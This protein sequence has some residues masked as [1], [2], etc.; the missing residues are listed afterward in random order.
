M[1]KN[2]IKDSLKVLGNYA[3]ALLIYVILLYTFI[4]I[5]GDNFTKWLPLYSFIIFLLMSLMLYTDLWRLAAKEKRP[6]YNLNPYPLKGLILGLIG[7][8]PLIIIKIIEHFITFED[9]VLNRLKVS[10]V[11]GVLLG[12]LYF[13]I[14]LLGKTAAAYIIALLIV[15][16]LS[17]LGYMLGYYGIQLGKILGLKKE[18]VYERKQELSPWNPARKD[19]GERKKKKKKKGH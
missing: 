16:L 2:H 4:A 17:M 6:Q 1:F 9:E 19:V 8:L 3:A 10:I 11:D 5:T 14:S 13:S 18:V 7:S 15:P 12:P